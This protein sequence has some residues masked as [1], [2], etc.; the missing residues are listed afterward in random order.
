MV[1]FR[2]IALRDAWGVSLSA[3]SNRKLFEKSLSKNFWSGG[4]RG[5]GWACSAYGGR[6][7]VAPTVGEGICA[8]HRTHGGAFFAV[9]VVRLCRGATTTRAMFAQN[10]L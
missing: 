10:Y 3:E 5:R 9:G 6:P 8:S 4:L 2:D 1:A 7:K